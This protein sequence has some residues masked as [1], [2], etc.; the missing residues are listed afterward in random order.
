[1][2]NNITFID[3]A[4]ENYQQLI[5]QANSERQ[6]IILETNRSGILQITE[7]LTSKKNID[8]VEIFA[9]GSAGRLSLGSDTLTNDNLNDF[10][11]KISQWSSA[12]TT[13]ADILLYSCNLAAGESGISLIE[14]LSQL[15]N[16]DIAASNNLT[17]NS[18]LG[19]DWNL[20]IVTG[21]VETNTE[22]I[23]TKLQAYEY[24]LASFN[25]TQATDDGTGN[26]A[27]TLSWAI[28]QANQTA[29]DDTINLNTDVRM[30]GTMLSLIN[31]NIKIV[32]NNRTISGDVNN[33]SINDAGDVRPLFIK[34]GIVEISNLNITK[35]RAQGGSSHR[36]GG[37]AGM[38]GGLFIYDGNVTL[39][40]VTFNDNKALGGNGNNGS[41]N[42]GGG[43]MGGNGNRGGGGLFGDSIGNDGGYGGNGNYGGFAG[44][45]GDYNAA[46]GGFG[47][48]GGVIY[49]SSYTGGKG[50][51]GGG[52]AGMNYD[53][54]FNYGASPAGG[55]GGFGGGGGY[56]AGRVYDS[57]SAIFYDVGVGGRGGYGAGGGGGN[58]NGGYGGFGGGSST[59]GSS[60]SGG[61]GMGGALFVR[62]GSLALNNTNFTNNS[63][64]GGTGAAN[65]KG[66][67]GAIFIMQSLTNTNGNNSGMPTSLA[68]VSAMGTVTGT[69]NNASDDASTPTN[70]NQ[71]YG[72]I[73]Y[74]PANNT[75]PIA[76]NDVASVTE[77]QS[78]IISVLAND[79]DPNLGD[80]F[81]INSFTKPNTGTL[82]KNND[83]TFTYNA[84]L[85]F[86]G[87]V[88]FT[89]KIKDSNNL[90]SNS[91]TVSLTVLG[92]NLEG[93]AVNNTL[94]GTAAPNVINGL[95][96]DDI[97]KG[98]ADNDTI[99]SGNGFNDFV[100]A[101]AGDDLIKD[102]D[103]VLTANGESGNDTINLSFAANWDDD[104]NVNTDPKATGIVGGFGNDAIDI[105]MNNSKLT[106]S[107]LGDTRSTNTK[108]GN[109]TISLHGTYRESSVDLGG[110]N[111]SFTGGLSK[112]IVSA[113]SGNDTLSG[114]GGADILNGDEGNDI[115]RGGAGGDTLSGGAGN[116]R[117]KGGSEGDLFVIGTGLGADVILDFQDNLDKIGLQ[118]SLTLGSLAINNNKGNTTIR[119]AN[120]NELL[121]TL[122][123]ISSS[124]ITIADFI[125]L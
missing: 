88:S 97:I 81:T 111:D 104:N 124:N 59:F 84:P 68:I 101:G 86:S 45:Y 123:G 92:L 32:G 52:G 112:D 23:A 79:T 85:N 5:P 105:T 21:K 75:A 73:K 19:G 1:M 83:G 87:S 71:I 31:S 118:G 35:G 22:L 30:T 10:S 106:I 69:N 58:R 47:G 110:G 42:I 114:F 46:R 125:D 89:Y 39:N 34:S 116:D 43:G 62:S 26:T 94:I 3:S 72:S 50:G 121:A 16:A 96:G 7:I 117:L 65:G 54:Y 24:V 119:L 107:L 56:G 20:E 61:A 109:D 14:R 100:L 60:G 2:T 9:H 66:L 78:V 115:L 29:G 44:V 51:F 74:S 57:Y 17:G 33:N 67:G 36:G 90:L 99:D 77:G 64:T 95:D 4:I 15:T 37:G 11:A 93:T 91:A 55:N 25:V 27:G 38:G 82:V 103:G 113:K 122:I 40:N 49:Y 28:E 70:N 53:G 12:L 76:N 108:D 102:A 8:T 6:I 18:N 41:F 98:L 120:T 80:V 63:A 13:T 48:G